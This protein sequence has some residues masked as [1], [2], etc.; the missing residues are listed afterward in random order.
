MA[1]QA[2][3]TAA[4]YRAMVEKG[5]RSK[6][7]NVRVTGTEDGDF[8]SGYEYRVWLGLKQDERDGKIEELRRQVAYP[9]YVNAEKVCTYV[10]DFVYHEAGLLVVADAKGVLTDVYRLKKALMWACRGVK[11]NEL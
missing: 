6:Y 8:D 7:R 4:E 2:T 11:I 10:A 9:L 3:M 5:S 1:K